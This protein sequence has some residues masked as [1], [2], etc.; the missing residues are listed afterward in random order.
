LKKIPSEPFVRVYKSVTGHIAGSL[1][2]SLRNSYTRFSPLFARAVAP[3][4]RE[5]EEFT[6]TR[7]LRDS[8]IYSSFII[9]ISLI[10]PQGMII[11]LPL[12]PAHRLAAV[13]MS[14]LFSLL[15]WRL[16]LPPSLSLGSSASSTASVMSTYSR[17]N[18]IV[19][20][21]LQRRCHS[22]VCFSSEQPTSLS[23]FS[24][25][26]MNFS[27]HYLFPKVT[28]R[29]MV[30]RVDVGTVRAN[31]VVVGRFMFCRCRSLRVTDAPYKHVFDCFAKS[32][33]KRTDV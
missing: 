3:F 31:V 20:R 10:D 13:Q 18:L 25:C 23:F 30:R 1:L 14:S 33:P 9:R 16:S 11:K 22:E 19:L 2:K 32:D 7:A 5:H 17:E 29:A 24:L 15:A 26:S 21:H 27:S 4:H 12:T 6:R 8:T 28:A